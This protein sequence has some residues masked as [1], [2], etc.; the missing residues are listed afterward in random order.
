MQRIIVTFWLP[1][2]D[3]MLQSE[4][5]YYLID[6]HTSLWK[7]VINAVQSFWIIFR[8]RPKAVI[9]TGGGISIGCS[10]LGK[11]IGA[12]LIF[13]ESGARV[14][15]PSRTGKFLYKY[16]DLFIVQWP[17]LLRYFPKAVCGG[18]LL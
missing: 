12:K 16:S 15:T 9:N 1:H 17:M 18:P 6:P 14:N 13:I 5:R 7:F 8:E 11:M 4:K 2:T 3:Q 10:L